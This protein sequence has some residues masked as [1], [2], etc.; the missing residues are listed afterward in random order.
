MRRSSRRLFGRCRLPG[1]I[2]RQN[3]D[4]HGVA[5]RVEETATAMK[6]A[7]TLGMQSFWIA[8]DIEKACPALVVEAHRIG[9][10]PDMRLTAIDEF[11]FGPGAAVRTT[12]Q[13]HDRKVL[14]VPGLNER[15]PRQR[16][17]RSGRHR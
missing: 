10:T 15:R 16:L 5:L 12:N 7:P 6:M 13:Q 2:G 8:A 14:D 1:G 9:W 17:R 11:E 4:A 3:R